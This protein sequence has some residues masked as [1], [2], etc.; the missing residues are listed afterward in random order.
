MRCRLPSASRNRLL[1]VVLA[2][3]CAGCD[4][5]GSGA[6]GGRPSDFVRP[7]T[8]VIAQIVA[9]R[10]IS[11]VIE[12]IGT[13]SANE[14]VTVTAKVTD[15]VSKVRFN[16]GQYVDA[17]D[18]LV[19]LTNA[20]ETALLAEAEANTED[21]ERQYRRLQDLYEKRSIPVSQLDEASARLNAARA[22]Y[23][24]I[25]A[26]LNDRLVRA[27]FSGLLGFRQVSEGTLIAPGTAIATL[28][29]IATIKLDFSIPEVHLALLKPGLSVLAN[30]GA[31]PD[32]PFRAQV[33]TIDTRI[34]PVTRSARVRARIDNKD[35]RLK[36]G[37]LLT[38]D[39]KT[40]ERVALAIPEAALIA[41]SGRT[42][43]Y[44]VTQQED[45]PSLIASLRP[46][47]TG[48][49]Y[50]GWI[51]VISGLQDGESVITEGTI[52]VRDRAPIRL[53]DAALPNKP[54]AG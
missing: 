12:A 36:P 9:P 51:E 1:S 38:V 21:A 22:R 20:E 23:D 18:I 30:S 52:K 24:S 40:R 35:L 14:S 46:V 29:D 45:G 44:V 28:D 49:R 13:T 17:G 26:R 16:D 41:R 39:L 2:L 47:V 10:E 27:P 32:Q 48:G 53:L 43:V 8:A 19:E 4:G 42:S 3:G 7:P 34:D 33:A 50:D 31:Y 25:L 6:A 37:M 11:D 54:V 15:T 5:A